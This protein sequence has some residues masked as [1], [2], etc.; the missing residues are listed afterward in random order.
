MRRGTLALFL[1]PWL[2]CV[3]PVEPS[4][5]LPAAPP[6]PACLGGAASRPLLTWARGNQLLDARADGTV[7]PAYAFSSAA[8]V[9][10]LAAR[11]GFLLSSAAASDGRSAVLLAASGATLWAQQ[12]D[13][14]AAPV[15]G[16]DGWSTVAASPAFALG[17]DGQHFA[18]QGQPLGPAG[19]GGWV[20]TLLQPLAVVALERPADGTVLALD[21]TPASFP[22]DLRWLDDRVVYVAQGSPTAVLVSAAPGEGETQL[23]L[24]AGFETARLVDASAGRVLVQGGDGE[25][26]ERVDLDLGRVDQVASVFPEEWTPLA[27]SGGAEA[28]ALDADGAVLR[29]FSGPKGSALFRSADLGHSWVPVGEAVP[30]ASVERTMSAQHLGATWVVSAFDVEG[31][32][33]RLASAQLVED[34]TVSLLQAAAIGFGTPLRT[35]SLD[36]AGQC[37]VYW[38]PEG[39]S[40][41]QSSTAELRVRGTNGA[42]V[43]LSM[44]AVPLTAWAPAV[45]R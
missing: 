1:L 21:A 35:P 17:P 8:H 9:D 5:D 41:E 19:P 37:A 6:T 18:L 39:A 26:L 20:P 7:K 27:P 36:A 24:G 3:R 23:P 11:G 2:G 13:A 16:A 15:L 4:P 32:I 34:Q 22:V 43:S 29:A 25:A 33:T 30:M 28:V 12:L 14:D 42:D 10:A 45:W 40:A 31:A 44:E 38:K